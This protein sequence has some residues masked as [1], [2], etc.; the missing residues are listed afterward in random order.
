MR[1][2]VLLALASL[3]T[4]ASP[5]S[6]GLSWGTVVSGV[7]LGIG[8]GPTTPEPELRLVFEDVTAPSVEIPLGGM[9]AKGPLYDLLFRITSPQGK[10]YTLF[11]MNGPTGRIKTEP[12]IARLSRGQKY[13]ILLPMNKLMSFED[14]KNRALPEMLA[15]HY[16]V[17]AMLDT[18]G[19]PREV[20]SYALWAGDISSGEYRR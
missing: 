19:N 11:N 8:A 3:A 12:L 1:L 14:G 2:L 18:T 10:E 9:T 4:A 15:A 20:T 7:R 6:P 13:E 5:Y 16:S 17:R